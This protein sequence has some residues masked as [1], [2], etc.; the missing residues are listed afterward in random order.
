MR[1]LSILARYGDEM[2]HRFDLGFVPR[3]TIVRLHNHNKKVIRIIL[4]AKNAIIAFPRFITL[5][6]G[7]L[8]GVFFFFFFVFFWWFVHPTPVFSGVVL[9][10]FFGGLFLF[11]LCEKIR[12]V[13]EENVGF[14][15]AKCEDC[16]PLFVLCS[17]FWWF[18]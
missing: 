9:L 16:L 15:W 18:F 3:P 14:G 10:F 8:F 11:F 7:L 6:V 17:F 13:N 4:A 2:G 12:G 5:F 1:Y